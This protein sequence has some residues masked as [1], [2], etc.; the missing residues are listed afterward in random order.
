[1]WSCGFARLASPVSQERSNS[2]VQHLI[3]TMVLGIGYT[4]L[5]IIA[6]GGVYLIGEVLSSRMCPA[7]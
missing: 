4:E 1:M 2:L 6:G 7:T 5:L 3:V